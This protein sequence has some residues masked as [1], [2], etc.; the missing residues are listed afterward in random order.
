M[1]TFQEIRSRGECYC[2]AR[3]CAVTRAREK[4]IKMT[5]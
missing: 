5:K 3:V 4:E 2:L 1:T